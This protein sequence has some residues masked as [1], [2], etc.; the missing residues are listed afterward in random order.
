MNLIG[1][2]SAYY[3]D[4]N[5]I[6]LLDYKEEKNVLFFF[7]KLIDLGLWLN[8]KGFIFATAQGIIA[9]IIGLKSIKKTK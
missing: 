1:W 3:L 6:Q 5:F 8:K 7:E 2:F 4:K 9:Y